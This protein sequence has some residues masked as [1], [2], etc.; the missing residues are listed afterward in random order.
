MSTTISRCGATRI[1]MGTLKLRCRDVEAPVGARC[2]GE[3]RRSI[4]TEHWSRGDG[5]DEAARAI[6]R[7][8]AHAIT[9]RSA[10]S[11][12][13]C[14]TRSLSPYTIIPHAS[15]KQK[16]SKTSYNF[17][18]C[19]LRLARCHDLILSLE[20]R[21]DDGHAARNGEPTLYPSTPLSLN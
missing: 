3:G 15:G 12:A 14:W 9:A 1:R 16:T 10:H 4:H 2:R 5:H 19:C 11:L 6:C 20:E 21:V 13:R 7:S 17:E 8:R 18:N